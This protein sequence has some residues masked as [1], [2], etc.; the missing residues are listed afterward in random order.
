[1]LGERPASGHEIKSLLEEADYTNG[2]TA[3]Y[4]QFQGARLFIIGQKRNRENTSRRK[5]I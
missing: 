2:Y 5:E 4:F 1:M 3:Y